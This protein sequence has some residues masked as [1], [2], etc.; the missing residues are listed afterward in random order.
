M[1][2]LGIEG[3]HSLALKALNTA[4]PVIWF[5]FL[6]CR[7]LLMPLL[8]FLSLSALSSGAIKSHCCISSPP[9]AWQ[10]LQDRDFLTLIEYTVHRAATPVA[11]GG[12]DSPA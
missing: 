5:N 9:H 8:I 1:G 7:L 3:K 12:E 2:R 6:L 10:V 4:S 11:V